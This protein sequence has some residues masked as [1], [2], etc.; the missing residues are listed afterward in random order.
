M[1]KKIIYRKFIC[2]FHFTGFSNI[3]IG[4]SISITQPNIEFHVP[5]GFF[6]VGW[7]GTILNLPIFTKYTYGIGV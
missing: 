2:Y 3:S 5:F 1:F 4:I 7:A 6:R